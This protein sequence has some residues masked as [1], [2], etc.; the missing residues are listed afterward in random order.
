MC[1][2]VFY[3][4]LSGNVSGYMANLQI[5]IIIINCIWIKTIFIGFYPEIR[6][7]I[8]NRR[9]IATVDISKPNYDISKCYSADVLTLAA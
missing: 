7:A 8:K 9:R 3:A 6:V 5:K 4:P 2:N 1:Y